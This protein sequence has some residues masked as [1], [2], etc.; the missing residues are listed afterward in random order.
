MVF[1]LWNGTK[2]YSNAVQWV[3]Q[4]SIA[5]RWQIWSALLCYLL[6]RFAAHLSRWAGSFTRLFIPRS[7][8]AVGQHRRQHTAND[9]RKPS[10]IL[11]LNPELRLA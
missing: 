8:E 9:R 6:L 11:N 3:A 1:R 4:R 7:C 2:L 10:K 5:L